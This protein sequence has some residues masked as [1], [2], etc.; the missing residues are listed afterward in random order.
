[1][2]AAFCRGERNRRWRGPAR[3]LQ[4]PRKACVNAESLVDGHSQ[5]CESVAAVHGSSDPSTGLQSPPQ[6]RKGVTNYRQHHP[7]MVSTETIYAAGE[8]R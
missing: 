1:M 5:S 4:S 6:A 2:G 7:M 3:P 8:I